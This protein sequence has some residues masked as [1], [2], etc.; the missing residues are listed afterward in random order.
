MKVKIFTDYPRGDE[1]TR[2]VEV[3]FLPE[4]K[5][6]R[7]ILDRWVWTGKILLTVNRKKG[8]GTK[9]KYWAILGYFEDEIHIEKILER[10][11]Q[12]CPELEVLIEDCISCQ[13]QR[14]FISGEFSWQIRN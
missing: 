2:R 14:E 4:S 6:E 8:K 5:K 11:S 9:R 1:K 3:V 10:A 12:I 7:N 13:Q